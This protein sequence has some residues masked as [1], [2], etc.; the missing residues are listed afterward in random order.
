[1]RLTLTKRGE[2]GIRLVILL[3]RQDPEERMTAA[4]LAEECGIPAGNVPTIV[5]MLSRA[6][7]LSC[8]PGRYGGCVLARSAEDIFALEIIEVLEG[9][10][11]IP[12]CLLDSR[13]C[14]DKD[15]ECAVHHA[16]NTG[17]DAAICVPGH[18]PRWPMWSSARTRSHARSRSGH[19]APP[20]QLLPE[21]LRV[22]YGSGVNARSPC[23]LRHL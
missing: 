11:E 8:S 5:S 1:M 23:D 20:E 4:Q 10:L 3:A 2:Y 14:H 12:H 15:P 9:S 21:H 19:R 7:I 13:R 16:W 17:R 18:A 22:S 6:G